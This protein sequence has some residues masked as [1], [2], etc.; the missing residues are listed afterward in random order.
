MFDRPDDDQRK[1]AATIRNRQKDRYTIPS[2]M[3]L[4]INRVFGKHRRLRDL[5][6]QDSPAE[7]QPGGSADSRAWTLTNV[8]K[9]F[10]VETQ[11]ILSL[12]F[13]PNERLL[14][15]GHQWGDLTLLDTQKGLIVASL[16]AHADAVVAVAFCAGDPPRLATIG[17]SGPRCSEACLQI[18]DLCRMRRVFTAPLHGRLTWGRSAAF[19]SDGRTGAF[20]SG[21]EL[22][23]VD[24]SSTEPQAKT[25]QLSQPVFS[26]AVSASGHIATIDGGNKLVL[27]TTAGQPI[28]LHQLNDRESMANMAFDRKGGLLAVAADRL[29]VFSI[30]SLEEL[31]AFTIP[32]SKGMLG[33]INAGVHFLDFS[34]DGNMLYAAAIFTAQDGR[35]GNILLFDIP[36]T[37]P[38]GALHHTL[39]GAGSQQGRTYDITA[40]C[41]S[42]APSGRQLASS[43]YDGALLFWRTI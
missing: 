16:R 28:G 36:Q 22:S 27:Q 40:C 39:A 38:A 30:P 26:L 11:K 19:S 24:L 25:R 4:L 34:P 10:D 29:R 43:G 42:C 14:V 21:T 12:A 9:T 18:W 37:R 1:P 20:S 33:A 32:K 35:N 23:V 17:N 31:A 41:V 15:C 13:S 8:R 2:V 6:T 3:N 5:L 7:R